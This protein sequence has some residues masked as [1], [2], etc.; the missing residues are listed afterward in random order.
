MGKKAIKA[1]T[2]P[3]RKGDWMPNMKKPKPPK[4]PCTTPESPFPTTMA[5]TISSNL[6][7]TFSSCRLGHRDELD[8][9]LLE[10]CPIPEQKVDDDHHEEEMDQEAQDVGSD[11]CDLFV[12]EK[13]HVLPDGGG[14]LLDALRR[15]FQARGLAP[16]LDSLDPLGIALEKRLGLVDRDVAGCAA[17]EVEGLLREG[18]HEPAYRHRQD[19]H[20]QE[21]RDEGGQALAALQKFLRPQERWGKRRRQSAGPARWPTD[22]PRRGSGE[23]PLT[24]GERRERRAGRCSFPCGEPLIQ[25]LNEVY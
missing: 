1:M 9:K 14:E 16:A 13:A 2:V 11:R 24:T 5:L 23:G 4:T 22:R 7:A 25:S 15:E 17:V 3:H 8:Q 10:L 21:T 12:Q 19:H 20:D 6:P 18:P